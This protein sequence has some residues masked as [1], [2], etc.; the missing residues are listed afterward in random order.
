MGLHWDG[1]RQTEGSEESHWHLSAPGFIY[2]KGLWGQEGAVGR[3]TAHPG[4]PGLPVLTALTASMEPLQPQSICKEA[5]QP[6]RDPLRGTAQ[7]LPS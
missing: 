2:P 5:R 6:A 4:G 7:A 3:S 1:G